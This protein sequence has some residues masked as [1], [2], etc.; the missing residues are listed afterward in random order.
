MSNGFRVG[1]WLVQ[2]SLNTISQNGT[3]NRLEPKVMEVLVCLSRR[4]GEAITKEELLQT[5]WPKTF[6]S[7]DVL[8]RSISELRRVFEDD[9]KEPRVI[10]TIA[11][12]GYRLVAPV[13]P[14][15]A[16]RTPAAS[17]P[18]TAGSPRVPASA[19]RS[20]LRHAGAGLAGAAML[21]GIFFLNNVIGLLFPVRKQILASRRSECSSHN[22]KRGRDGLSDGP[23]RTLPRQLS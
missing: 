18:Q 12:R 4:A 20:K 17:K 21:L 7:D 8:K 2:P 13:V 1:L 16:N 14:M 9:A 11:K 10:Q 22:E 6:V 5:V 15:N 23:L 3:S 19:D